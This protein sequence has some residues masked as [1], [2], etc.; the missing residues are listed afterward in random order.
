L[1]P[2]GALPVIPTWDQQLTDWIIAFQSVMSPNVNVLV[3]G[4]VDPARGTATQKTTI[5]KGTYTIVLMNN[6]YK[7]N[8]RESH[9]ALWLDQRVPASLRKALFDN[10]R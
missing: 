6:A 10:R 1:T 5:T 9:S 8:Q 4:I 3:D 7:A 2:P